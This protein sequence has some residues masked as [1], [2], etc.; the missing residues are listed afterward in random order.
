M[1]SFQRI[2]TW[3]FSSSLIFLG[4]DFANV[5][6]GFGNVFKPAAVVLL[7][8]DGH[9]PEPRRDVG[10]APIVSSQ[11]Q[12]PIAIIAFQQ[13]LQVFGSQIQIVKRHKQQAPLMFFVNVLRGA[14][15]N[16]SQTYGLGIRHGK[17]AEGTFRADQAIKDHRIQ[18]M[19][20]RHSHRHDPDGNR[21]IQQDQQYQQHQQ[22][23]YDPFGAAA[24]FV[25]FQRCIAKANF[26]YARRFLKSFSFNTCVTSSLIMLR[27]TFLV[28]VLVT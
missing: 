22:D 20:D 17:T 2:Y 18:P 7:R 5:M 12:A 15:A 8:I 11:G 6:I 24:F 3:Y 13:I 1:N 19:P 27:N 14:F 4:K 21:I 26:P 16:L 25:F 10:F 9:F 23:A 28:L